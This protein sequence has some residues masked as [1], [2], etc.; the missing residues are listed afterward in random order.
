MLLLVFDM[1]RK[2]SFDSLDMWLREASNHGGTRCPL[3]L[4]GNKA[5]CGSKRAVSKDEAN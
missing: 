2:Q 3:I 1:S 5:D 4:I